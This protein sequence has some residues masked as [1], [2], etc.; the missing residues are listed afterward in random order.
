[1]ERSSSRAPRR[2]AQ[3]FLRCGHAPDGQLGQAVEIAF[4]L[5]IQLERMP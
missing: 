5:E 4:E 2:P 1:M 3:H